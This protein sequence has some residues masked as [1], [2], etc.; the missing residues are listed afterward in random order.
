MKKTKSE[1]EIA[2]ISDLLS[3]DMESLNKI[4]PNEK[5]S[6]KI[7]D[8]KKEN[9][10]IFTETAVIGRSFSG[11]KIDLDS[12]I[13]VDSNLVINVNNKISSLDSQLSRVTKPD[14]IKARLA[15]NQELFSEI[16]LMMRQLESWVEK[17]DSI[18]DIVLEESDKDILVKYHAS[19][20]ESSR[21]DKEIQELTED[22]N[23][24]K[25]FVK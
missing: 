11:E 14:S 7:L 21:L 16:T 6:M 13:A 22:L 4:F 17:L 8:R 20:L 15:E 1:E 25:E 19:I 9:E 18:D 2:T 10:Q 24:L 23:I 3:G 5:V 12:S